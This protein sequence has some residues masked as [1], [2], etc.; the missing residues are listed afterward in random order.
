MWFITLVR[1]RRKPTK[2]DADAQNK[3]MAEAAKWGVKVHNAFYTLGHYDAVWITE[4]PDEKTVM[5][6]ALGGLDVASTRTLVAV[7]RD[8]AIKW[9]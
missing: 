3:R 5:R 4:A 2:A 8:E 7:T 9:L 1:F 6:V